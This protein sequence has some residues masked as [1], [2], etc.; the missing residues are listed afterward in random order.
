MTTLGNILWL[1]L[2]GI[3]MSILYF[4]AGVVGLIFI[5]TIP[6]G[7]QAFKLANYVLWPF[8]RTVVR[9]EGASGFWSL[10]GNILWILLDGWWLAL[11]HLIFAILFF[12]T[13]IGI[14]FAVANVKLARLALV[15]FGLTVTD[16]PPAK[17][18][19]LVS[20]SHLGT[21]QVPGDEG[22]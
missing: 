8:G 14:P 3:W 21:E 13:I 16:T 5:V 11:G 2:C 9:R 17:G 7:I 22:A 4:I 15:P 12:V 19:S 20:V 10:V 6:F 18:E 1:L